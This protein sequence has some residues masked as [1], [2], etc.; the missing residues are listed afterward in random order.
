[1]KNLFL[2][3][4]VF[5]SGTLF[6]SL[7][8][9][10]Q[11]S[12]WLASF[13]TFKTGKK[14]S[15]HSDIQLR[16]SDEL[17]HTQT[18]LL[19][20]GL[21]FHVTKKLTLTTGYAFVYNRR[22]VSGV[23]GYAPEHRI[24]EQLLYAHKVKNISVSHRFRL[25]QRFISKT[26]VQNNELKKD[27]SV[28]ANR[29]RYFIRNV[30]PFQQQKT[31]SKGVFAALQNE[32]F[33]NIGNTANVNGKFFDQNRLYVAT[34]YRLNSSF[35]LETGYLYQYISGRNGAFTKNHVLQVAAYLR[36]TK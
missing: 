16:S 8:A 32:V 11:F 9:Q 29:F 19:R 31:F 13:N 14:T 20:P 35:D 4:V 18:L 7:F 2:C 28:Y 22:I 6:S 23:S 34:G 25:E 21:N 36:L 30:I 15:I 33:V 10:S 5:L 26:I 3:L 17:K 24:W 27:G 12:G 1:M